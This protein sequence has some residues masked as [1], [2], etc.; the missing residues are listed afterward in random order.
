MPATLVDWV[1]AVARAQARRPAVHGDGGLEWSYGEL[2]ER[3]GGIA[4]HLL[5]ERGLRPGDR[6]GLAGANEPAYLAAYFGVMRAG[7]V[8]VPLNA[9][10]DVAEMREQLAHVGA[11]AAIAGDV[12]ADVREGLGAWPLRELPNQGAGPLPQPRPGD[13]ACIFLTSGSTGRPK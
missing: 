4:R 8:V 6:V 5:R 11:A 3:A 2:W 9:M 10:L 13:P 7:A 1:G 12:G